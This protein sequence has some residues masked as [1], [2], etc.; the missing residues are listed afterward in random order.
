MSN[1]NVYYVYIWYIV[2]TGE[3]FYVGKGKKDRYKQLSSRNKFFID[4]YN[5][6]QCDVKKIYENLT[7]EEAFEKEVETI[8]WYRENTDYRLT[9]QTDGGEGSSGWEPTQ[10]F[11]NKQSKIHIEQ[12]KNEEFRG[13]MLSIRRD[14]NGVYKS[15]EFREKISKIVTGENN[16]NYNHKWSDEMKESLSKYKKENYQYFNE[17]NPN[18]KSIICIETGE[19]FQC[20]KFAMDKY[21]IK[22][23]SSISVALNNPIRTAGDM[24]WAIYLDELTNED[25]RRN[26]LINALL[27][28]KS[29]TPMICLE[30]KQIFRAA[31][32]IAKEEG[33]TEAAVRHRLKTHGKIMCNEKTYIKLEDYIKQ[34]DSLLLQS[35]VDN[36]VIV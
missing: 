6:H 12:W 28:D 21:N 22:T 27:M 8:K 23:H 35:T 11:K 26:Y 13:R 9:N 31:T 33:I 7:E 17:N 19:V 4:M 29:S 16:P 18:A 15:Q 30:T 36:C 34:K 3:V 14:E 24:H 1:D 2:D 5:S 32:L 25:F 20:I 10:E